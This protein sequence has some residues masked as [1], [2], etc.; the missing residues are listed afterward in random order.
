MT[1]PRLQKM[2][3]VLAE[4]SLELRR[5]DLFLIQSGDLAAPLVREVF[6]EALL[7][8]AH[9]YL[10]VT[11][12]GLAEILY[13]NAGDEQLAYISE[14]QKLE[15]E[16]ISAALTILGTHNTRNLSGVDPRRMA[17]QK[18]AGMPLTRKLLERIAAGDLRWCA[19]QFP[20]QAAA[21][22]ANMSLGQYE[23]FLFS[24]CGVNEED[25]VRH[26]R[27]LGRQQEEYVQFLSKAKSIRV[28]GADVDL[29]FSVEGRRWIN[30]AGRENFPDG[31]IF[32]APVEESMQGYIRFSYPANYQGREVEDVRLTFEKGQVVKAE[33]AH[34]LDFLRAMLESDD[35][36]PYVG[37]FAFGTNPGITTY[38]RNTLFDEK[39]SGTMHL[40]LGASL[41][42]SGG[43]NQSGIHWDLVC[44]LRSEGEVQADGET[45]YRKGSFLI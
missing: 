43:K 23:D 1:D 27:N 15:V 7:A 4:Y 16:R 32:T 25:P 36:A 17:L 38:T 22:D 39:I 3:R 11:L 8:G 34:G 40:A 29:Q 13:K 12:D 24:A 28:Q 21:Q 10:K 18:K 44:D 45:F 42:E 33:A 30:C 26:W 31:E 9:P 37:E 19:T 2:A 5:G 35:G 20:T 14:L 6:Y 41:P